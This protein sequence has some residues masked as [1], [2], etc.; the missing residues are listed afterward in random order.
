MSTYRLGGWTITEKE[1]IAWGARLSGKPEEEVGWQYASMVVR[2]HL[3][4]HGVTIAAVT[5]PKD[6]DVLMVVTKAEPHVGWRRGDDPTQLKQFEKGKY[7]ALVL[8]AL[9]REGV[10]DTQFVTSHGRL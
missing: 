2:R 5:Y 4:K 10:K 3:R 8:E 6:V 1:A 7:E 9:K